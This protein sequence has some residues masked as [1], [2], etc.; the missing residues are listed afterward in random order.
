MVAN[1]DDSTL[2]TYLDIG[3]LTLD[4]AGSEQCTADIIAKAIMWNH[5]F[6]ASDMVLRTHIKAKLVNE[7]SP[8]T[9][10]LADATESLD[11]Q[12]PWTVGGMD[13]IK[14]GNIVALV[15]KIG[16]NQ[17]Y[18]LRLYNGQ[19]DL[20]GGCRSSATDFPRSWD[21][22]R[23]LVVQKD[24]KFAFYSIA[25]NT[26]VREVGQHKLGGAK[27]DVHL[28]PPRF[29]ELFSCAP[30][31]NSQ[32][33][34]KMPS[35]NFVSACGSSRAPGAHLSYASTTSSGDG[36]QVVLLSDAFSQ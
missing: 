8:F 10:G 6:A 5:G 9:Q 3:S 26:Y 19:V 27:G 29:C 36:F 18:F 35:G 1:N 15:R 7:A 11:G 22:E 28:D 12:L 13:N 33:T 21:S 32:V 25:H 17:H 20:A 24:D 23:F 16:P 30:H 14:H 31:G 34:L 2:G 4:S